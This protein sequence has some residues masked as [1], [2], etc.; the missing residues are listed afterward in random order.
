MLREGRYKDQL[1]RILELGAP[2]LDREDLVIPHITGNAGQ[3]LYGWLSVYK[4]SGKW[5]EQVKERQ[6]TGIEADDIAKGII[7]DIIRRVLPKLRQEFPE[8]E[9]EPRGRG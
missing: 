7:S 5:P 3:V 2:M 8:R 1:A 4:I 9:V 6:A